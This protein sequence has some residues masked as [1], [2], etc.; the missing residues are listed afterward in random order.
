MSPD[1][2]AVARLRAAGSVFAE[3]EAA[4]LTATF[5]G[6]VLEDAVARRVNGEPLEHVLGWADFSGVRVAVRPPVFVPRRRAEVLV[7]AAREA[8]RDKA[9]DAVVVD[10]GCGS[11]AIAAALTT[12]AP[13]IRCHAV[14]TDHDAVACAAANGTG[15]GFT[16]HTGHWLDAL[17]GA[18]RHGVDVAVAHLPYVPTS[19]L[20]LLPRDY[21]DAEP[22][23]AVDGGVDGLDPLR[24]VAAQ[25][26]SWLAPGGML[27]TQVTRRQVPEAG[28]VASAAGFR[29]RV[30]D[31]PEGPVVVL[32]DAMY[33]DVHRRTVTP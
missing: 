20:G 25:L 33:V 24:Q 8:L 2:D 14:D 1:D 19:D 12:R 29:W 13:G 15:F 28:R 27:I 7:D 18:L 23:S 16:V 21:R 5:D 32:A 11:G 6:P 9:P 22:T 31:S 10:V 26:P 3:E 17:P 30:V 4:A